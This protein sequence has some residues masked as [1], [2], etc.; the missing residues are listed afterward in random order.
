MYINTSNSFKDL[1]LQQSQP[2]QHPYVTKNLYPADT[3]TF[4]KQ[5]ADSQSLTWKKL[6]NQSFTSRLFNGE[7][8]V[9]QFS[10]GV[11]VILLQDERLPVTSMA[12]M[13]KAG[14]GEETADTAGGFHFL[15]HV[16]FENNEKLGT[17][18]ELTHKVADWGCDINAGTNYDQ[19]VYIIENVPK[20]YTQK[21]LAVLSDLVK[22]PD[23]TDKDTDRERE[24]I[25]SEIRD[26]KDDLSVRAQQKFKELIFG[27][28]H[29]YSKDGLGSETSVKGLTKEKLQQ[30]YEQYYGPGNQVIVINGDFDKEAVLKTLANNL[31]NQ[32]QASTSRT[33]ETPFT[34]S[35]DVDE[36]WI[37]R[38][39]NISQL[40]Y[41]AIS[42]GP[43]KDHKDF[44]KDILALQLLTQVIV[45]SGTSRAVEHLTEP[46]LA[47]LVQV[48]VAPNH[49]GAVIAT[50]ISCSPEKYDQ[51]REKYQF[52][53]HDI[54]ENGITEDELASAKSVINRMLI[55]IPEIH[56]ARF[57]LLL[58]MANSANTEDTDPDEEFKILSQLTCEDLQA[59]ASKYLLNPKGEKRMFIA[60]KGYEIPEKPRI[61][62]L[63]DSD[64]ITEAYARHE[65]T[66]NFSGRL[67]KL[68]KSVTLDNGV[69]V[70]TR[71]N[72]NAPI[73]AVDITIPGGMNYANYL[74]KATDAT[75]LVKCQIL[76]ELFTKGIGDLDGFDLYQFLEKRGLAMDVDIDDNNI[77]IA[78]SGPVEQK[79]AILS[80]LKKLL[81]RG[82][83]I[84]DE[85][86]A[87]VIKQLKYSIN[88]E[89]QDKAAYDHT[90]KMKDK[91]FP[92]LS[93]PRGLNLQRTLEHLGGITTDSLK[94]FWPALLVTKG[95]T[96]SM[97]GDVTSQ[98]AAEITSDLFK[99]IKTKACPD[100]PT[101]KRTIAVNDERIGVAIPNQ[102]Q[103]IIYKQ[104]DIPGHVDNDQESAALDVLDEILD[105]ITGRLFE[106]ARLKA[107]DDLIYGINSDMSQHPYDGIFKIMASAEPAKVENTIQTIERVIQQLIDNPP[108]NEEVQRVINRKKVQAILRHQTSEGT[109]AYLTMHRANNF[110]SLEEDIELLEQVTPE[111]VQAVAKKYLTK[112]SLTILQSSKENLQ[113]LNVP[114]S[115]SE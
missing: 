36:L 75:T 86:L 13:I 70:V 90:V 59:V 74:D 42:H 88:L 99:G 21:G 115:N 52:I 92:D 76:Q 43:D 87:T 68:D 4:G 39:D 27:E 96:V 82:P 112:P 40:N 105:G 78:L 62:V 38:D 6:D 104:W 20:A 67:S 46:M 63:K 53:L 79:D 22:Y 71:T 98:E 103:V 58:M 1:Y 80:F 61:K 9:Y 77:D 60:P 15:E 89:K 81:N 56:G 2:K 23:M 28:N 102:Q 66:V 26:R 32:E 37:E 19:T 34:P 54:V 16:M 108:S 50:D 107:D 100:L 24:I 72:S 109:A 114:L 91:F 83:I 29:P 8:E 73:F 17:S 47:D 11:K 57:K 30:L 7:V 106:E 49:H 110:P 113:K 44:K 48:L 97:V 95:T 85:K 93:S 94:D 35:R 31:N 5:Q 45:G 3:V 55:N 12:M 111:Q 84:T 33:V 65:N 69:E 10:N 25:I 41:S 51:V 18:K 101:L 64:L 14:F